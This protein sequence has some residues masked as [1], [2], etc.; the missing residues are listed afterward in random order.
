M[1]RGH[2][3]AIAAVV[4]GLVAIPFLVVAVMAIDRAGLPVGDYALLNLRVR[5]V[6]SAQ[7]PLVGVYSRYGWNHPGPVLIWAL[8]PLHALTGGASWATPVGAVLLQLGAVLVGGWSAWRRGGPALVLGAAAV[9]L[10]VIGSLGPQVLREP[11]NPYVALPVFALLVFSTWGVAVGDR[12]QL[13]VAVVAGAA[14]VQIHISYALLVVALLGYAA[15]VAFRRVGPR[16]DALRSWVPPLLVSALAAGLLWLPTIVEQL[17]GTPGNLRSIIGYVRDNGAA[18]VGLGDAVGL[19]A[20]QYRVPMPWLGGTSEIGIGMGAVPA[21]AAWLLIPIGL[22]ALSA[23][24]ARRQDDRPGGIF[25]GLLALANVVGVI[26]IA[27]TTGIAYDYLFLWRTLLAPLTVLGTAWVLARAL[28]A[29]EPRLR[30]WILLGL[31]TA[32][33]VAVGVVTLDVIRERDAVAPAAR[34]VAAAT[35]AIVPSIDGKRVLLKVSGEET[36]GTFGG[37]LDALDDRGVDVRTDRSLAFVVGSDR[38]TGADNTDATLVVVED[39]A[40]VSKL[41]DDPSATVRYRRSPLSAAQERELTGL[42]RTLAQDLRRLGREDLVQH[43]GSPFLQVAVAGVGL[44]PAAVARTQTLNRKVEASPEGRIAV[45]EFAP[46]A[47]PPL[48]PTPILGA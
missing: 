6:Y 24:V 26:T 40:L 29:R 11:W 43:L 14:L 33:V 22:L 1:L 3:V 36:R 30:P 12:W 2:R 21:G 34:V 4:G 17:T 42:H 19:L 8:A 5:D 41:I 32:T 39:S 25:V 44:E 28:A 20:A 27:G 37:L 48:P 16:K 15:V 7:L 38:A 47:V 31:A 46:G 13:P 45:F 9:M 35:D 18:A 10:L 23:V